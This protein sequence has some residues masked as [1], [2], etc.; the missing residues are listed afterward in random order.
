MGPRLCENGSC[1]LLPAVGKENAIFPPYFTQ[2]GVYLLEIPCIG[3]PDLPIVVRT[4][5]A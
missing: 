4:V 1:A 2:P 5:V 3:L